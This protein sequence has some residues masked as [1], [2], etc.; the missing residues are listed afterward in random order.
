MI[1]EKHPIIPTLATAKNDLAA[2]IGKLFAAFK[3]ATIT[4]VDHEQKI[5]L[6]DNSFFSHHVRYLATA[7]LQ[8]EGLDAKDEGDE[9]T[10]RLERTANT[11]ICIKQPGYIIRVLRNTHDGKL[12]PAA[13]SDR[14]KRFFAQ[15]TEQPGLYDD[16]DVE[17]YGHEPVHVVFLWSSDQQKFFSGFQFICPKGETEAPHFTERLDVPMADLGIKQDE[18]PLH[19]MPDENLGMTKKEQPKKSKTGTEPNE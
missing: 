7:H 9:E 3:A 2:T 13:D 12:P 6:E 16:Q 5:G 19:E 8:N 1:P 11:G 14:R 17:T 10:E 18:L 15:Q 4:A